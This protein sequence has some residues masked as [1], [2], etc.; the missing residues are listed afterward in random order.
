LRKNVKGTSKN[1]SFLEVFRWKQHNL[2]KVRRGFA[3]NV[4]DDMSL[5]RPDGMEAAAL[6]RR[7]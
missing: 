7:I 6:R 3:D 1:F 2:I 4:K 5:Y